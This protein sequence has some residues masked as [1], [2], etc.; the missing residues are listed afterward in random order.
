MIGYWLVIGLVA[1]AVAVVILVG[2]AESP[3]PSRRASERTVGFIRWVALGA[4]DATGEGTPDPAQDNWVSQL[5]VSIQNDDEIVLHNLGVGGSTLAM[6]RVAQLPRALELQPDIFTSWLVVNDFLA[7]VSLTLY[8]HELTTM[9]EQ[10]ATANCRVIVGNLPDLSLLPDMAGL[11]EQPELIRSTIAHW[12]AAIARIAT[13]Y[14]ATVIDL[15]DGPTVADDLSDDGFHPSRA[16]HAR[17]AARFLPSVETAIVAIRAE[18]QEAS[19]P[20]DNLTR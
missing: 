5:R 16:G 17:L 7:G 4:S 2:N 9:L 14:G 11:S 3:I 12:N 19:T 10:L 8:E 20:E 18:R 13:A 15:G 6:A 1:V